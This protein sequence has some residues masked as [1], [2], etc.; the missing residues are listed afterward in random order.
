MPYDTLRI[1]ASVK[2][3]CRSCNYFR[4]TADDLRRTAFFTAVANDQTLRG[5]AL[6]EKIVGCN[7]PSILVS[8]YLERKITKTSRSSDF[9]AQEAETA[10]SSVGNTRDMSKIRLNQMN[11]TAS[12]ISLSMFKTSEVFPR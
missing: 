9:Y 2:I 1:I 4:F 11:L 6:Y 10:A 12:R 8:G 3:I 5:N 7:F